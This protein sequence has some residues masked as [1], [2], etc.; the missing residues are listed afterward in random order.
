MDPVQCSCPW[1]LCP[2]VTLFVR[3]PTCWTI[4][5]LH[6]SPIRNFPG[7]TKGPRPLNH[8]ETKGSH[9]PCPSEA[10]PNK[11][12][13]KGLAPASRGLGK[14]EAC[15]FVT[16][17]FLP[18]PAATGVGALLFERG[19]TGIM[20]L[21]KRSDESPWQN[22]LRMPQQRRSLAPHHGSLWT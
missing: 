19:L 5:F 3:A 6:C 15:F 12:S 10:P 4:A 8:T 16:C 14:M 1:D 2:S 7:N 13:P 9:N 17:L 21:G 20:F 18:K 11:G 22:L